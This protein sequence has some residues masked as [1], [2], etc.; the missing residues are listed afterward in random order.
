MKK[1]L[2]FMLCLLM[3]VSM[4]SCEEKSSDE[5]VQET[6]AV[7]FSGEN[8]GFE[9]SDTDENHNTQNTQNTLSAKREL[10]IQAYE[11]VI[12]NERKLQYPLYDSSNTK[13]CYFKEAFYI[14]KNHDVLQALVDMDEDGIEEMVTK[15]IY[16]SKITLLHY[17]NDTV[18]GYDLIM[19]AM[20]TIYSDGSFYW[21]Y[22]DGSLGDEYGISRISFVNGRLKFQELCR[23]ENDANFYLN[24]IQVD[25]QVYQSYIKDSSRE[26]IEFVPFD[27]FSMS[28]QEALEIASEYWGIKNGEFDSETG[29]RYKLVARIEDDSYRVCLYCFVQNMYYDHL[30]CI[31]V[32]VDTGETY[33]P[34]LPDA[35][36]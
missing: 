27:V 26:E 8:S 35:K 10:A 31:C 24:G 6:S 32:N 11:A 25:P 13:E 34:E 22:Y 23:V 18:Y 7:T 19:N 3:C 17:E 14:G 20:Q 12:K 1:K 9:D 36:G 28:E 30:D 16:T 33:E 2:I 5:N 4:F 15:N 29:Y 21:S